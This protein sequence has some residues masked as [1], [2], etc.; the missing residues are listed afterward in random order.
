MAI[1]ALEDKAALLRRSNAF[2]DAGR[3]AV[4]GVLDAHADKLTWGPG[5]AAGP[6]G[7]IRLKRGSA[8]A[9]VAAK[10]ALPPALRGA[11]VPQVVPA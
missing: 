4:S 11:V 3:A 6:V 1:A 5:P 7:W 9:Y 2:V 10:H 8:A